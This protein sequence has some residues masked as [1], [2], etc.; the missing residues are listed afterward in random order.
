VGTDSALAMAV[1]AEAQPSEGD[2]AEAAYREA[3]ERFEHVRVPM[4]A[5]RRLRYGEN[6]ALRASARRRAS[7][8]RPHTTS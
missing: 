1:Q 7:G 5:R 2:E 8:S 3:I 4:A 6:A